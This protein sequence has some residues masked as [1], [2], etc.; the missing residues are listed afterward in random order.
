MSPEYEGEPLSEGQSEM[1]YELQSLCGFLVHMVCDIDPES[2]YGHLVHD[3]QDARDRLRMRP[4][5]MP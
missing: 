3:L 4:R 1:S 2:E 5:I